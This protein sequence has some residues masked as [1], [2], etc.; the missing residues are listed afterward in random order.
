M[1]FAWLN[2]TVVESK[3][4]FESMSISLNAQHLTALKF[5]LSSHTQQIFRDFLLVDDVVWIVGVSDGTGATQQ[6]L[7]RDVGDQ[8][9]QFL[10]PFPRTFVKESQGDVECGACNET[11]FKSDTIF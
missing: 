10:Q 1:H 3:L 2:E 9:T 8:L 11:A 7:E 5:K 4:L 6:H